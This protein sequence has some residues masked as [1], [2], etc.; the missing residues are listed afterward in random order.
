MKVALT[1]GSGLQGMSAL[2]Y[3]LEQDLKVVR[4]KD[5]M[6]FLNFKVSSVNSAIITWNY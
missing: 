3:L 2:I 4:M 5:L 1:G 6:H